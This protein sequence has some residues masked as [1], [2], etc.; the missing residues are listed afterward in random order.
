MAARVLTNFNG[1]I[2][3][4]IPSILITCPLYSKVYS[5][6]QAICLLLKA[7]DDKCK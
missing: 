7:I 6:W 3:C 4:K 1:F 5:I 2:D